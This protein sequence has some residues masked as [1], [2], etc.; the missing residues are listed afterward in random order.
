[1][2]GF[3]LILVITICL[4]SGLFHSAS[5]SADK[6]DKEAYIDCIN[7]TFDSLEPDVKKNEVHSGY[8]ITW[9]VRGRKYTSVKIEFM[10]KTQV[11]KG[12]SPFGNNPPPE[13]IKKDYGFLKIVSD[14]VKT[15]SEDSCFTYK[16]TC[17][18]A[19]GEEIVLDPIIDVPKP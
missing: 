10:E 5:A 16:I 7:K 18:T 8:K 15:S 1:M 19:E 11:C 12:T 6:V 4:A 3:C 2:K 9:Y 13:T 17:T 14:K